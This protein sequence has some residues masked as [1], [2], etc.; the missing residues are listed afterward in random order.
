MIFVELSVADF[1]TLYGLGIVCALI[2]LIS[3]IMM[4]VTKNPNLINKDVKFR[5]EELFVKIY[6]IIT[7]VFSS[8]MAVLLFIAFIKKE[9]E[10]TM[11]LLLGII[12][13]TMLLIQYMLQ[14]KFMIK[15]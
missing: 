3:G 14:R 8:L 12:V 5:E 7:T 4:L 2:F 13:I 11:F 9:L 10:L 1:I 15:K 6:G